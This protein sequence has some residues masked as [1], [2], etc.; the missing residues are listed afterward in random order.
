MRTTTGL[1]ADAITMFGFPLGW[2]SAMYGGS[3]AHG[4]AIAPLL[5]DLLSH[6]LIVM[7]I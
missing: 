1:S 7:A 3:G 4:I 2:Y 5:I 6:T